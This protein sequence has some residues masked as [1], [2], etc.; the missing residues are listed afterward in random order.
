M[1]GRSPGWFALAAAIALLVFVATCAKRGAPPGGPEDKISPFVVGIRPLSGSVA[2]EPAS[3]IMIEFSERMK[4]RTVE[5]G[6]VVSP[7]C[8]W[9]KRYWEKQTYVL[10]PEADLVAGT[11]YLV[12]VSNKVED[13]HGVGMKSTFVAGFST[14]D[15]I[16]AGI[17]RGEVR[18]KNVTVEAAVVE[19]FRSEAVDTVMGFPSTRPLYLTLSGSGGL[20]EIP[21]VNTELTYRALAFLD[22]N[23]NTE[24]DDGEDIG[25]YGGEVVLDEVSEVGDVNI[26]LC[27]DKLMGTIIG[28]VDTASIADT[29]SVSVMAASL[30]DSSLTYHAVPERSGRFEM[31]CVQPG[32][33]LIEAFSDFNGNHKQ[34][35]EDTFFVEIADTLGVESCSEPQRL[36]I[37]F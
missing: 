1:R 28:R 25:C 14:G 30:E 18:W 32:E 15:S 17:V 12:S 29:I 7:P 33:Y 37:G 20:Y 24:Y 22:K 2:V 16:D 31:R 9:K 36:E 13:A 11:T 27:G 19:L 5:T 26:R 34:D 8:R 6:V 3:R 21:F 10:I 35:A 4:K 23:S